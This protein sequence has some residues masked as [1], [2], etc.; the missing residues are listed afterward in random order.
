M[1]L[2]SSHCAVALCFQHFFEVD[3]VHAELER[4]QGGTTRSRAQ[5]SGSPLHRGGDWNSSSDAVES[6]R[7]LFRPQSSIA[8]DNGGIRNMHHRAGQASIAGISN[9]PTAA[10]I[11]ADS[12]RGQSPSPVPRKRAD[13]LG[14]VV[15]NAEV[16]G[17][18]PQR[19]AIAVGF[20]AQSQRAQSA[21][22]AWAAEGGKAHS[23]TSLRDA[24]QSRSGRELNMS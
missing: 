20:Q 4:F 10:T 3:P 22:S 18:S 12:G 6:R 2:I 23:A 17:T 13:A 16:R 11:A 19:A 21:S 9:T 7:S 14:S 8:Q 1:L 5:R 24:L 15:R